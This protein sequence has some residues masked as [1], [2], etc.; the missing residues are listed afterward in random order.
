MT[1]PEPSVQRVESVEWGAALAALASAG[2]LY[3]DFLTVIDR[4]Q[5]LEVVARVM[6]PDARQEV[7][8]TTT[9]AADGSS[10][11]SATS[12]YPGASWHEREA[13]EMF[14]MTFI[15]LADARPLLLRD[16]SA[17]PPLRRGEYL[18]ARTAKPWPGAMDAD[19]SDGGSRTGR[20]PSRRMRPLG[21]PDTE[22]GQAR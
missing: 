2:Y 7:L 16:A 3:L 1:P 13:R 17:D 8:I 14:G 11:A 10:L 21:V 12:V 19:A 5:V 4:G 18:V 6:T 20:A 22:A 9:V 15:G